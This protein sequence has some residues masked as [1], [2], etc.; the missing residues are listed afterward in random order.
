MKKHGYSK[1]RLD[2][3]EFCDPCDVIKREQYYIN[4]LKPEYNIL[5][6][7][8]SMLGYKHTEKALAKFIGRKH[9]EITRK[10]ISDGVRAAE[11]GRK[12]RIISEKTKA[13]MSA[14]ALGRRFTHT[15][16]TKLKISEKKL[17][18]KHTE[19]T[20]AKISQGLLNRS[21]HPPGTKI[22]VSNIQTGEIL[23][24]D[25]IRSAAKELG[26]NHTTI[27]NYIKSKKLFQDIYYINPITI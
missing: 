1:F 25:S 23:F 5:K 27:R 13:K 12:G 26:T 16:E 19:I 17:G 20:K 7:A 10:K 24:Y 22:S 6:T 21:S 2:I 4:L 18:K 11:V 14:S 9:S 8:G 15:E 3:L